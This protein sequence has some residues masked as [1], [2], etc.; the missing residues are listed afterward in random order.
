MSYVLAR[1]PMWATLVLALLVGLVTGTARS[2][3]A[4]PSLG[5][6][7]LPAEN[8]EASLAFYR[9]VLGMQEVA[10]YD[11]P[12][13]SSRFLQKD[14]KGGERTIA[15]ALK[16]GPSVEAAKTSAGGTLEIVHHTKD[17]I[18]R[19]PAHEEPDLIINVP[20]MTDALARARA[21]KARI[22][23]EPFEVVDKLQLSLVADPSGNVLELLGPK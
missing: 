16:F 4:L 11:S 6:P 15:V 20:S 12:W 13:P 19:R 3:P 8:L 7:K 21:H 10:R 17:G 23:L 1:R 5:A 9:D 2:E 22:V 14:L 18:D